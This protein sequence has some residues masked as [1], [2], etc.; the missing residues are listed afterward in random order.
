MVIGTCFFYSQVEVVFLSFYCFEYFC[1]VSFG[2]SPCNGKKVDS[3]FYVSLVGLI[4]IFLL[5][6]FSNT[7]AVS[8]A[9]ITPLFQMKVVL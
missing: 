5:S 7:V 8:T 4:Y 3:A 2:L 9:I 1:L 6:T